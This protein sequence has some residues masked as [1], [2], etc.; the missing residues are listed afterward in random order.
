MSCLI[1]FLTDEKQKS[2]INMVQNREETFESELESYKKLF[3]VEI[4][5]YVDK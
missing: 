3:M 4:E 2:L 1:D 5:S